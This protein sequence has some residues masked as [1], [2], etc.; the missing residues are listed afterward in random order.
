MYTDRIFAPICLAVPPADADRTMMLTD[1]GDLRIYGMSTVRESRSREDVVPVVMKSRNGGLDWVTEPLREPHPGATVRSPWSGRWI[2]CFSFVGKKES[3]TLRCEKRPG[4]FCCVGD[5]PDGPFTITKIADETPQIQRQPLALRQ[6]KC[7]IQPF[8]YVVGEEDRWGVYRSTDDGETWERVNAPTPPPAPAL[9]PGHA[10]PRWLNCGLEPIVAEYPDGSLHAL[11]RGAHDEHYESVS[12][13][14]GRS[15]SEPEPSIFFGV[16]TMPGLYRLSGDRLLA[17]WN[18]TVPLP[19]VDHRGQYG[20]DVDTVIRGRWEDWFTNRDALHA[21]IS[22]DGG[23]SWK[24]FREIL[25]NPAR[26]DADFRS[27]FLDF[28]THDK[29]VH[30]NQV[31]ELADGTVV[32]CAGQNHVCRRVLRFDPAW[33]EETD[34]REDFRFGLDHLSTQLY[35]KSAAGGFR[36]ITGHCSLNRR[37]GAALMP[38][39]DRIDREVLL[40]GRHPDPRLL[41]DRE[42]AVWNFPASETGVV[43]VRFRLS[44]WSEGAFFRLVNRWVNPC[45]PLAEEYASV[46]VRLDPLGGLTGGLRVAWEEWHDLFLRWDSRAE[47][48]AIRIDAG[49]EKPLPFRRP[50]GTG[51]SYLHIQSAAESAD[52]Y[53]VLFEEFEKTL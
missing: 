12:T 11:L 20:G 21:A 47:T 6:A 14:L 8:Q 52:P 37:S 15:W 34:V 44:R 17:V 24:G 19:E 53:G 23:K 49:E 25:L 41:L 4:L 31:V 42:G 50:T 32:V 36:G 38:H 51:L 45:D 13:D 26:N 40:V 2:S 9:L 39:P 28:D 33:L 10:G 27:V 43:R 30:Q 16:A 1:D 18:N 7:W 3:W 35:C 5:S 29:S 48:A 22:H 46:S